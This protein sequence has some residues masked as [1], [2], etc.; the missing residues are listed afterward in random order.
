MGMMVD[1]GRPPPKTKIQA[2]LDE[3]IGA[4]TKEY[5][6]GILENQQQQHKKDMENLKADMKKQMEAALTE[7]K[8]QIGRF[9]KKALEIGGNKDNFDRPDYDAQYLYRIIDQFLEGRL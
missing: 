5:V 6:S 8:T 1:D 3:H 2:A 7:Q 4:L 9:V